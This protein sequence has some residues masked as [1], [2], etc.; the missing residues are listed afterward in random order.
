MYRRTVNW[1]ISAAT[2][3]LSRE[4]GAKGRPM[5]RLNSPEN[6][7]MNRGRIVAVGI[8]LASLMSG[9]RAASAVYDSERKVKLTGPVTKIDW[10]N[11]SAFLAV[12]VRDAGGTVI[13]W[14]V[15][16]GNPLDLEKSGWKRDS[17]HTGDVVNVDGIP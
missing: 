1:R 5:G 17:L 6:S 4:R 12:N 14:E 10:T 2:T 11:P 7:A 8:A 15:E 16:L 13:T 9:Q 3:A